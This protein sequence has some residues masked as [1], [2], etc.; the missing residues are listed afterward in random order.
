[1]SGRTKLFLALPLL[2]FVIGFASSQSVYSE[3]YE[4]WF[5]QKGVEGNAEE[6]E[7]SAKTIFLIPESKTNSNFKIL[8]YV[9]IFTD[10]GDFIR[11]GVV[12]ESIIS[13]GYFT[14]VSFFYSDDKTHYLTLHPYRPSIENEVS[15]Y[16]NNGW[17]ISFLDTEVNYFQEFDASWA[18]GKS[19][20][21]GGITLENSANEQTIISSCNHI[22]AIENIKDQKLFFG[23]NNGEWREPQIVRSGYEIEQQIISGDTLLHQIPPPDFASITETQNGYEIG[24]DCPKNQLE[25]TPESDK[26]ITQLETSQ[27]SQIPDWVKNTMKWYAE[28][29]ISEQEMINALQYL[30]KEG[31]IKL[32]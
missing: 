16:Y 13:N 9:F 29:K 14:P 11:A 27:E 20:N 1:V 30:V 12:Y 32:D 22:G 28:E 3:E 26:L 17:K 23:T 4:H 15:I 7:N 31:T 2:I 19:I 8:D 21:Y 6:G 10:T 25:Q 24:F 18:S 5:W